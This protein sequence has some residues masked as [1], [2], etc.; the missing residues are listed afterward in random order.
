M[1]YFIMFYFINFLLLYFI[2]FYYILLY[3]IIFYYILLYFIIF[4]FIIFYFVIF[5]FVIIS[6][7]LII[8]LSMVNISINLGEITDP[9]S[10]HYKSPN[11][12][13]NNFATLNE[14]QKAIA[15]IGFVLEPYDSTKYM[16]IYGYGAKFFNRQ[17]VEFD[18]ALTGNPEMPA[19][20][21]V[22][23]ILHAYANVLESVQICKY[24]LFFFQYYYFSMNT[25]V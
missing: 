10:L 9:R 17:N 25:L 11:C 2:I 7:L 22:N 14:Y 16:E 4:Y 19:V 18:C 5:Y 12:D 21:G 8:Y 6:K 23:G 15:A 3:F 20:L 13:F 24:N 1:F